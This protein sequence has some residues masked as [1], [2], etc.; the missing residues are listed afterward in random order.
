MQNGYIILE[1]TLSEG[2]LFSLIRGTEQQQ[3]EL[4]ARFADAAVPNGG[5]QVEAVLLDR[6]MKPLSRA[7]C[8]LHFPTG[9]EGH[10]QFQGVGLVRAA[11]PTDDAARRLELHYDGATVFSAD[12]HPQPPD[13][14]VKSFRASKTEARLTLEDCEEMTVTIWADLKDGRRLRPKTTQKG[15]TW[16]IDLGTLAGFGEADLVLE[17]VAEFRSADIALGQ[18]ALPPSDVVAWIIEPVEDATIPFGK[19]VSL[20]ATLSDQ[21]GRLIDWCDKSYAWRVDGKVVAKTSP[22]ML[23]WRA[24]KPGKH[25]VE[26][27]AGPSN[28]KR[29]KVLASVAFEVQEMTEAQAEYFALIKS[30][31]AQSETAQSGT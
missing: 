11:L 28:A 26:V 6:D 9:C 17:A 20:I 8:P 30:R 15:S 18:V 5:R 21:N 29:P 25:K 10:G 1:G 22:Q 27:I 7:T 4:P 24:D 31:N 16:L 13:V 12:V 3:A 14:R 19:T 23:A 2:G